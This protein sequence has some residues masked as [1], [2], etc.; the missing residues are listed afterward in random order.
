MVMLRV[1]LPIVMIGCGGIIDAIEDSVAD[2]ELPNYERREPRIKKQPAD[3]PERG[4]PPAYARTSREGTLEVMQDAVRESGAC[5]ELHLEENGDGDTLAMRVRNVAHAW[6]YV[7]GGLRALLPSGERS[8]T[9]EQPSE[10]GQGP[11]E[12]V[13]GHEGSDR[14]ADHVRIKV[15]YRD[16]G[17]FDVVFEGMSTGDDPAWVHGRARFDEAGDAP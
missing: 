14:R 13:F 10:R 3:E 11:V 7:Q 9:L 12:L 1:L 4:A 16:S 8:F 17:R 6:L 15:S 5:D 2:V